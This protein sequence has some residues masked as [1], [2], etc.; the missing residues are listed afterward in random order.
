[1]DTKDLASVLE[2]NLKIKQEFLA[3]NEQG[4]KSSAV[5]N[6]LKI[7]MNNLGSE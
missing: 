6:S 7:N 1:M 3:K 4:N 2:F 5:N